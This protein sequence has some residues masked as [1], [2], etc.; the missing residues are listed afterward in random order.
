MTDTWSNWSGSVTCTPQRIAM[1]T[2]EADVAALLKQ[3]A[4]D[5]ATVRVAGTGHSFTPLCASNAVLV[6]LDGLQGLTPSPALPSL[7]EGAS[8]RLTIPSPIW[9]GLGWGS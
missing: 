8:R 9:G 5:R 7:G 2:S 1:P 6:S 3:A 4:V